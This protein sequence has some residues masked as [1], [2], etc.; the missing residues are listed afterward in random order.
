VQRTGASRFAQSQIERH[1][2]LAPVADLCA[3]CTFAHGTANH[4]HPGAC[5]RAM[6][7]IQLAFSSVRGEIGV[8]SVLLVCGATDALPWHDA[9]PTIPP[10]KKPECGNSHAAREFRFESC[11]LADGC[12]TPDH[13][14][15]GLSPFSYRIR[16]CTDSS[17]C[18]MVQLIRDVG[19]EYSTTRD[20]L[21]TM[22]LRRDS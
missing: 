11:F 1:R 6:A 9:H 13:R 12:R 5:N 16:I 15:R 21:A 22:T 7:P 20:S 14:R 2:R 19:R 4:H 10:P 3:I 18:C 17:L 8:T